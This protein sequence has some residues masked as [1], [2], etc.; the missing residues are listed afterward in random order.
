MRTGEHALASYT[1]THQYI[2][3]YIHLSTQTYRQME[4]W[5]CTHTINTH[6][7]VPTQAYTHTHTCTIPQ[8]GMHKQTHTHTHMHAIHSP[9]DT[10]SEVVIIGE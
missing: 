8:A 1:D 10:G 7:N 6:T 2:H 3:T 9:E 4:T 5:K